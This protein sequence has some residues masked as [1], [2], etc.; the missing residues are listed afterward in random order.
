[1]KAKGGDGKMPLHLHIRL[2][3]KATWGLH[4]I[5]RNAIQELDL[6]VVDHRTTHVRGLDPI[7]VSDLYVQD[8]N[9]SIFRGAY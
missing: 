7:I 2:E 3:T 4:E 5:I 6:V 1:M 9:V 8:P